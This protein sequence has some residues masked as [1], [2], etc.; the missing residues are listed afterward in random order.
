MKKFL[1][2]YSL[3]VCSYST[4]AQSANECVRALEEAELAFEQGRLL[5]ILEQTDSRGDKKKFYECLENNGFSVEEEIRARKLL[6]KAYLF[7]DNEEEAENKLI[8]L[9]DVDK[10][11]QLTA[12]DPAELYFLYAKFKTEPIFRI[13]I[14]GGL[15]IPSITVL[16]EFNTFASRETTKD[17]QSEEVGLRIGF[18]AE[19]TIEKY[20]RKGIEAAAGI[21][22]RVLSY[23]VEGKIIEPD[24]LTYV[25]VNRSTMLRF[26]LLIRYN[27]RYSALNKEGKRAKLIPYV[28]IGGSLDWVIDAKY[29]DTSRSGG[30]TFTLPD[31]STGLTDFNQTANQNVSVFGGIG[32]KY[33]LG[34]AQVNFFTV[35][36]RY[37]NSLFNYINPDTRW[38][39]DDLRFGI[40]HVED[41]LTIN[42]FTFSLGFT[43]SLYVPRKRK[44]FR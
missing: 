37:E 31:G 25:A 43:K 11:H 44:E 29:I 24:Q 27:Y 17:Y 19:A 9:L 26:P 5:F 21:Q 42:A 20:I 16:Q 6:V 14:K 35:E 10:E 33:R 3:S 41:D 32:A 12:E 4:I 39:N 8:D 2:I 36:L 38:D 7:T 22:Y 15:N 40:G 18:N 13:A 23:G 34:R 1:L 28:Y 30:V